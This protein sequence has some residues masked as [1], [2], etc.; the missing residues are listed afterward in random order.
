VGDAVSE[1]L[2]LERLWA[3]TLQAAWAS[4]KFVLII[5]PLVALYEVLKGLP[6]FARQGKRLEPWAA[7]LHFTPRAIFPL[8]AGIFLGLLYGAGI[9]IAAAQE[10]ELS[11]KDIAVLSVFLASCHAIIEDTLLFV[12]LG[13]SL[14]WIIGF[15]F[16]LAVV[17]TWLVGRLYRTWQEKMAA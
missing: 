3:Y 11:R 6:F 2:T 12:V 15:R 14:W 13:A 9:I 17:A 10:R 7:R 16:V 8:V 1:V 5:A 4:A